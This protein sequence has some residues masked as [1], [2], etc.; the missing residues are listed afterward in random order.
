MNG[1]GK[2]NV[3]DAVRWCSANRRQ[4]A[5]GGN[6][7]ML[8]SRNRTKAAV[9]RRLQYTRQFRPQ[10]EC[11]FRGNHG[12][13]TAHRSVRPVSDEQRIVP[14][15]R[16]ST[17]CSTCRHRKRLPSSDRVTELIDLSGKPEERQGCWR[18]GIVKFKR[19]KAVTEKAGG[20][21]SKSCASTTFSR[22]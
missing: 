15:K 4:A 20:R 6:M 17:S 19:R 18:A 1:S 13:E 14:V 10:A 16:T 22:N 12:D 11:R 21:S 2:S 7:Q 8:F 5:R 9:T 3:G